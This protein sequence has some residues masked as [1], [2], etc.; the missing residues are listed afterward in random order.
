MDRET[1]VE[2]YLKYLPNLLNYS[3]GTVRNHRA[4]LTLWFTYVDSLNVNYLKIEGEYILSWIEYRQKVQNV[5]DVTISMGLCVLRTFYNYLNEQEL[6][7]GISPAQYLPEFV[8]KPT[9]E[10]DYLSVDECFKMLESIDTKTNIGLRDYTA[11]A[12]MWS[13]G[14]R[15]KELVLLKWEDIDLEDGHFIVKKGKGKKQRQIYLNERLKQ[16]LIKFKKASSNQ[17]PKDW[18]FKLSLTYQDPQK[19]QVHLSSNRLCEI[20]KNI[21]KKAGIKRKIGARTIRHTF[22]T[23]MYEAGISVNDIKE[24]MGH[25]EQ[26]ETTIY[27][28]VTAEAAKRVLA[29]HCSE[30]WEESCDE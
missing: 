17:K 1:I 3:T 4:L 30:T 13:T 22:A 5:K 6:F 9:G 12:F 8:C 29:K 25:A 24:I 10:Q 16:D 18:I 21:A 14:I 7:R 20:I 19:K 11:L 26:S 28:H 15:S 2:N 27:I 23:H